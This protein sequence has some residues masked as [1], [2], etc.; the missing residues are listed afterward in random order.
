M[1]KLTISRKKAY[2]ACMVAMKVYIEDPINQE[3]IIQ[4]VPCRKLGALKNGEAKTFEISETAARVYV[5]GDKLSR[6]Y[7]NDY[8]AIPEG[9]EDITLSGKNQLNPSA[10]NPFY[11]DGN[12][13]QQALEN[14]KRGKKTG[15]IVILV[16]AVVGL[17][18]GSLGGKVIANTEREKEFSA[19]GITITLTD[20]FR[21]YENENFTVGYGA[22]DRSVLVSKETYGA[23]GVA[24]DYTIQEYGQLVLSANGMEDTVQLQEIDGLTCF[25]YQAETYNYL[26][27]LY[28]SQDAF[29]MVQ[30]CTEIDKADTYES[31]FLKMA[32]TVKFY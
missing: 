13:N 8:V 28:K 5:I 27:V 9:T 10:G 15:L 30:F 24:S 2:A 26:A 18:A 6:N 3:L 21:R 12:N 22:K 31:D 14:R 16:A 25:E 32:K 11:F 20:K 4:G 19:E 23:L 1:R 7:A 17:V 29:W